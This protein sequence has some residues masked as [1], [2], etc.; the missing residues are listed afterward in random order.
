TAW[1]G[2][3]EAY[4]KQLS[5]QKKACESQLNDEKEGSE[6]KLCS[7]REKV[8]ELSQKIKEDENDMVEYLDLIEEKDKEIASLRFKIQ[9]ADYE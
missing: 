4:E 2:Q 8:Q 6:A 1:N 9:E 3:K 5:D 7:L